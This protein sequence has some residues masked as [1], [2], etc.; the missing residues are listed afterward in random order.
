ML[1]LL[2]FDSQRHYTTQNFNKVKRD[3]YVLKKRNMSAV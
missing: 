2:I 1:H 3:L